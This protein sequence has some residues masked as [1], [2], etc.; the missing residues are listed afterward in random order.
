MNCTS[1][2]FEVQSHFAFC[3]K[4][5]AKQPSA[6]PGCGYLC[7]PDFAFCPQCGTRITGA[8]NTSNQSKPGS[9]IFSS[10]APRAPSMPSVAPHRPGL[11]PEADRRTVTILFADLCGYTTLSEQLDPEVMQTLQN[12][13]FEE[14]TAA[15]QSFGGFVDKF[16]GDALLALFGAPVAHEDD[17]ERALRA[18]LDMVNR[19]ACVGERWQARTGSP[20][21]LHVGINTGPVVTGKFGAGK[22]KSYSVTGDTVNSAQRLQ[23]MAKPGE[24]LV[25]PLTYRLTRHIFSYESLGD[26]ALRGKAGSV[27][28]HRLVGPLEAPRGAR[29]LETLGLSAPF[30]GRDAELDR[31]LGCLDLTCSGTA[32]LVRLIGEAGIGKSRLTEE[33]LARASEDVRF[34]ELV[35]RR[36][37]CSP[38][39]E[40][41]YGTLAAVLRSAYEIDPA[42]S[43]D[44]TKDLLAAGLRGLG[45]SPEE[46]N[47]LTPLLFYVLG[48][49][50]P[51]DMLRHVEP[52]QLRRQIFYAVRTIFERRLTRSPLLLVVEDLHWADTA[53]LEALRF[54]MDR[55]ER[56]RFMLLT[57]HRSAFN[58]ELLDSSRTS[59]TVLRLAPLPDSD[60]QKLLAAFFGFD[61]S[62]LSV[63]LCS[64]ILERASGNPL[65]IEEIVR[66][67]IEIG[68]L[69]R[70]GPHWRIAAE[71]AAAGIP[72]NIQALLLARMDRLSPEVRRLAQEAA[73]IGPRFNAT[74]LK[75]I[76]AD[77]ANVET[78]LDLLCDAEII[79][80]VTGSSS[81]SSQDYRFMQTLL[82]AVIYDNLLLQR[83]I[84]MHG[85]IGTAMERL[86]GQ[87]P[88]HL[89]DLALLGHHF[90]KTAAR[91]K[92]ACYLM[93]AGDR[94]RKTYAND[95][96]LRLYRQALEALSG[97]DHQGQEWLLLC[98]RIA[99]LCGPTGQ[100]ETAKEHYLKVLKEYRAADNRAATARILRKVG[101]ML[102]DSGKRDQAEARYAEATTL[103]E[104][105]DPLIEHAHLAQERGHLA[106]RTGDQAAAVRWADEALNYARILA[107]D[108][109][110][111]GESEA[112]RVTAEALNTKGV[113]LARLGRSEEAVREVERS[114]KVAEGADLLN[115]ACRGY[116][117]LGVLYTI[118]NPEL[119]IQVCRRGL[120]VARHI[121]DLGFQA[122]LLSN[123]AVAYCTFTDRCASE[124]V[125]AAE[126]AIEIDRALDQRDHLPVPLIVLGQIYQ[127]HGQPELALGCYNEALDMAQETR[128]PQL[129]F[130]C[131]DGLATLNLD[132]DDMAEAE[133]YFAMAQE[134]CAKHGLDPEALVV[135]PFLD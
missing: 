79:E 59:L 50:D 103:L 57:T 82:H 107:P 116:T 127:C 105:I 2:G 53:S 14:L 110:E 131:Y 129:L 120:K 23:S 56:S 32:Q 47:Q 135:L 41:S 114:V 104:G 18:A 5:G 87:D 98:E 34:A 31:M 24:V 64:R 91:A 86:H 106:F 55:M 12:E 88:E 83:R 43:S 36:A 13:L 124:G 93:A 90:S 102:W 126:K 80:E 76:S 118:V 39:G 38:L 128:E 125:P 49:D 77:P 113:A 1:C 132:L 109:G 81:V 134:V 28:V 96:A 92:G 25:G 115:V 37:Y 133:R 15:V 3:P 26:Q 62:R 44:K 11:E 123:L 95:D 63:D 111:E 48:L 45:L 108:S 17:P 9:G 27:P 58:T 85:Q 35:V 51:D 30:I 122:R 112:A 4:C 54:L 33:F 100:R 101:R 71:D 97:G 46:I 20:L 29:G 65:F 84:D 19:T 10:E 94:A 7:P 99:D 67:L 61:R 130:P 69:Q 52:E 21:V 117:N 78:G 42:D 8:P 40:Q 75:A 119:A 60:G 22:S 121:G 89:E 70:D 66:G 16:I 72:V 73:V 68:A 74:L 6:C